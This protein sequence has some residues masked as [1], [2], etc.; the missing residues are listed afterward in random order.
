MSATVT[1]G[2]GFI[3]FDM[4][5]SVADE[6]AAASVTPRP[7]FISELTGDNLT[8]D[9]CWYMRGNVLKTPAGTRTLALTGTYAIVCARIDTEDGTVELDTSPDTEVPEDST[10]AR[11]PLYEME[12]TDDAW[13]V[14]LDVRPGLIQLWV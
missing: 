2:D 1:R 6:G 13:N 14:I 12:K 9:K 10:Y 7:F 4:A 11:I 8:V 3:R 5:E